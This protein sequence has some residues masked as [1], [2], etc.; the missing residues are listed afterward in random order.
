[1]TATARGSSSARNA[2]FDAEGFT[3]LLHARPELGDPLIE[4]EVPHLISRRM[5]KAS[6]CGRSEPG[7]A[8]RTSIAVDLCWLDGVLT[9]GTTV[10]VLAHVDYSRRECL[11]NTG[12]H[13]PAFPPR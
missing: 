4:A 2:S 8:M 1:M 13:P 10:S 12:R 5:V 3:R 6:R 11:E 7:L 9:A